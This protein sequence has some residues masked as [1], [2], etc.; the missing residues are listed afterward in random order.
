[1]VLMLDIIIKHSSKMKKSKIKNVLNIK[2]TRP[3]VVIALLVFVAGSISAPLVLAD[4]YDDQINAINRDT[5][6]KQADKDQLGAQ[7]DSIND[8][9][10]RLQNRINSIQKRIDTLTGQVDELKRQIKQAE[11]ELALQRK[12]LGE[13]IRQMYVKDDVSTLEMLASSNNLS[14]F[15]DKQQ[16]RE[17]VRNKIKAS[18]DKIT[19]LKVQ[20]KSSKDRVEKSLREQKSLQ[21][22]VVVQRMEK[23]RILALNEGEQRALQQQM[24]K[25]SAKVRSLRAQQAEA[26]ARAFRNAGGYTVGGGA[27]C[28]SGSGDTYP[29]KWCA[30][31][32]DSVIDDWG[33]YNRECVSYTAWKVA[34]SGRYMPYW[35]GVGNANQWPGNARRAGISVSSTPRRG[36]VAIWYIGYYGHAMYVESVNANGTINISQYNADYNGTF[37]RVN[38]MSPAGLEFIHF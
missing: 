10:N 4:R 33:M 29:R 31:P 19:T 12:I 5:N 2:I 18:V 38:G 34:E 25:N 35:G 22:E 11:A 20:L 24:D 21:G 14:E 36:D 26:N 8:Q 1:M 32:Q 15:F 9:I 23:D 28:A 27:A 16:Y 13:I 3:G 6:E 17:S 7:A 30:I 37:S